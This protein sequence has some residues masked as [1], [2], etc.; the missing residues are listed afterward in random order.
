MSSEIRMVRSPDRRSTAAAVPV[1]TS[2]SQPVAYAK[3]E[4]AQFVA[5]GGSTLI[6]FDEL[7]TTS[8]SG[9]FDFTYDSDTSRQ[10]RITVPGTYLYSLRFASFREEEAEGAR[11]GYRA[12]VIPGQQNTYV[13]AAQSQ[14]RTILPAGGVYTWTT[15]QANELAPYI[16]FLQSNDAF[17]NLYIWAEFTIWRVNDVEELTEVPFS[18]VS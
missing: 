14:P 4:E 16:Y 8:L 15:T 3:M 11:T 7:W 5:T 17:E 13:D 6:N 9:G 10:I 2:A 1:V 12:I 18:I